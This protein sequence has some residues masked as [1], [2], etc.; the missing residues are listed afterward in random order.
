MTP[1]VLL[2]WQVNESFPFAISMSW[3]G[4]TPEGENGAA[5]GRQSTIVV[6][7]GSPIPCL[8]AVTIL[9]SGSLTVDLQ[10]ADVSDLQ[11]PPKI[12]TYTVSCTSVIVSALCLL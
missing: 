11:A 1:L 10:Y 3:K 8:K 7:K 9:R 5:E 12:S 6:P 2:S 4:H